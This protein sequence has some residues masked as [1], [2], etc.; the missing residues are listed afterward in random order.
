MVTDCPDCPDPSLTA[1]D[2]GKS[3]TKRHY[4]G[5]WDSS[6]KDILIRNQAQDVWLE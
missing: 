2:Q 1:L 3:L 5:N 4:A 6:L